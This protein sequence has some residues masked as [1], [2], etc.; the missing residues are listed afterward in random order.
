MLVICFYSFLIFESFCLFTCLFFA[1]ICVCIQTR[2]AGGDDGSY[3]SAKGAKKKRRSEDYTLPKLKTNVNRSMKAKREAHLS[4]LRHQSS[5]EYSEDKDAI[6]A[7]FM[8]RFKNKDPLPS[9]KVPR[10]QRRSHDEGYE[11]EANARNGASSPWKPLGVYDSL[12]QAQKALTVAC[13]EFS[14]AQPTVQ[15]LP[16]VRVGDDDQ[17]VS[18]GEYKVHIRFDPPNK[19]WIVEAMHDSV[20]DHGRRHSFARAAQAA[21]LIHDTDDEASVASAVSQASKVSARNP[22]GSKGLTNRIR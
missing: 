11:V 14:R 4:L 13:N 17:I 2:A 20:S 9:V 7:V 12:K 6:M 5:D 15:A 18:A 22:I 16:V 8:P 21:L 19:C 3:Y 1:C 10:G